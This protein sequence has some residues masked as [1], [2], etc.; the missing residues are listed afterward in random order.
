MKVISTTINGL[1]VFEPQVFEDYRGWFMETYSVR[2]LE[3]NGIT[4]TFIQ[5]NHAYNKFKGILRGLHFQRNPMAQTKLVRC[6][7]G[8]IIDV[9]VDLRKASETYKKWFSIELSSDNKKQLYIPQGFAHGYITLEDETEVVYKVDT[10]Y[11]KECDGGIQYNDPDIGVDWG[12][13]SPVLSEK[14]LNLPLLKDI[15]LDF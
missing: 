15:D 11:S 13:V 3:K 9:A 5:D 7:K 14:D 1:F 4:T 2:E 12:K 6:V 8:S 10:F